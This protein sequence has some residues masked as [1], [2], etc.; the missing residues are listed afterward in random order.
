MK[1][2]ASNTVVLVHPKDILTRHLAQAV[3]P[4][5]AELRQA[6]AI[7]REFEK[8][9]LATHPDTAKKEANELLERASKGDSRAEGVLRSAGGTEAYIKAKCGLFDLARAKF[10]GAAK[11]SAPLW[12]KVSAAALAALEAAN[13]EIQTQWQQACEH[14]GEPGGLSSWDTY[15]RN[16]RNGFERAPYAAEKLRQGAAWQIEQLGLAEVVAE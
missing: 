6:A 8:E 16:L 2:P 3:K 13:R 9:M 15:C 7:D 5:A 10:E 11:A 1:K 4:Y 12:T 14:L